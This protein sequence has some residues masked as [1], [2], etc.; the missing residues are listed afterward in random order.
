MN[1]RKI[2]LWHSKE[3]ILKGNLHEIIDEELSNNTI[4]K[5]VIKIVPK[6]SWK[7]EFP[8]VAMTEAHRDLDTTAETLNMYALSNNEDAV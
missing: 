2:N 7:P 8:S 6:T 4:I 1:M 3:A 5:A